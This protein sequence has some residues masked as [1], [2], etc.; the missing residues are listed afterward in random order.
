[1]RITGSVTGIDVTTG[2]ETAKHETPFPLLGGLLSTPDL[3]F[4]GQPDGK[5]SALDAKSLD[6]LWTFNTGGGDSAPPMTFAVDGKQYVAYLI[7][8]GGAWDKWFIDST[9]EL[10][11]MQ[12]SSTLYVFSLN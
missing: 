7:G 3:V 1:V 9:P 12:P 2:K 6:E 8:M 4:F 11:T 10:K 5:L